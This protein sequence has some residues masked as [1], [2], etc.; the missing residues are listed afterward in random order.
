M[1]LIVLW[2]IALVIAFVALAYVNAAGWLWILGVGA[3]L[4]AALA[5]HA[6][7]TLLIGFL[8]VLLFLL[9]IPLNW[10][11]LRRMLVSDGILAAFRKAL[12]PMSP[13]ERDAIEAGTV[14]WDG[15][16]FSGRPSWKKLLALPPPGLSDEE[17]YFLDHDCDELCAMVSDWETTHVYRDLSPRAW[18]FVKDRGF[19]G[20]IIP[21][22]Y[23]GLGFSAYAH[24]QV[25]TKLSTHASAVAVTVMVPNSLGPGELLLHYGTDEQKNYHLPRLAKGIEIPCFALTNPRAGSDAAAIPDRGIVC[26]GQHEGKATL[27]IRLTWDKRY[28][29]L[30]PVATLLGLAFRAYDPEHLLGGAEDL[31]I[32][33]ALIPTRHPGVNIGRRHM[34][35]NAVFQNGPNWGKDVFIPIDWVIGGRAQVGNGW[36]MLMESLAAGRGISLPSSST[37]MAKIAVRATGAYARVRNQFKTPIGK[38]EGVEEALARMGG[39]LYMMD[40]TRMLTALAVD[41][42]E[43]P[44]VLSGIAKY[45]LTERARQVVI[46]GMDVAGGKGV[47]MGPSNFLGAAYMQLPVSITV[48]GANILTRSLIIF[49]QGAIRC[50][51]FVLR[52]ISAAN[53]ADRS[54]ASTAFDLALIGHVG[55]VLSNMARTF[56][57]GLCGSHCARGPT[58]VAP[59]TRRYYQQLT[60]FSAALAFLA[61]ISMGVL[62]GALKRKEKLSARL[63]DVLSMLYLCSATLKRYEDE[64]RQSAD[65]PL[66]HWAIWDAMFR[67]QNAIEGVIS[68]FPSRMI[69]AL[70]RAMVFPLGRPYVVPSDK[71][72]HEVARLLI[73]P[74]A[75]RDRLTAGMYLREDEGDALGVIEL[76]LAATLAAEPVEARMRDAL[77]AGTFSAAPGAD[78]TAAAV[79]AGVITADE[80]TLLRR[81]SE[82]ADRVI[83]VDDFAQDLGAS[84]LKPSMASAPASAP[85]RKVASA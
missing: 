19:L 45:H 75:T 65:A 84:E 30:G 57:M 79:E 81:A 26:I 11:W 48:E 55:F 4:I 36:R 20:M 74:S 21:K 62:G 6:L 70:L 44:A 49:G 39:N 18:A 16:L 61:D 13:T 64:G 22:A 3:A 50:H 85:G 10:P 83:R 59:E 37:G 28:I 5:L 58:G 33:C 12:P 41:L 63:G 66:M 29:T 34:P 25:I 8:A 51:P 23:G 24:S 27:G 15:D 32:T 1:M 31:G 56:V 38:F 14:W 60:R 80:L 35:L 82:L 67:A 78:R 52:E 71:L 43:K 2:L 54:R 47:C 7:P 73:E 53:D 46:D 77:R 9:A 76:A 17:Q 68:N 40:A 72:G 69:S 42:G